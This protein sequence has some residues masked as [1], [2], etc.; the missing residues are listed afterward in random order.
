MENSQDIASWDGTLSVQ[1]AST[2]VK[3]KHICTQKNPLRPGKP[4]EEIEMRAFH[5]PLTILCVR[6]FPSYTRAPGDIINSCFKAQA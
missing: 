1:F 5:L 4:G 3:I 2:L 6:F